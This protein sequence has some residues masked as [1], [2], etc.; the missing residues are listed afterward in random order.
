MDNSSREQAILSVTLNIQG[1][2][3]KLELKLREEEERLESQL[4]KAK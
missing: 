4:A 1:R 2:R 3:E